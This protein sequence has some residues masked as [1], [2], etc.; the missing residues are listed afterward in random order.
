MSEDAGNTS[1]SG[2]PP[3]WGDLAEM[4]ARLDGMAAS[5]PGF[6]FQRRMDPSGALSYP[7]F[8]DNVRDVLGFEPA[9]MAVNAKG[10]LHVV[11]WADREN[12]LDAIRRSSATLSPCTE[13]FRAITRSGEVRWLKGAAKPRRAAD[14]SVL[15]DGVLIDVTDGRRAE[16]RLDMLMDHAADSIIVLNEAGNV[17]T[18]NVAA[19]RL[20]G[21]TDAELA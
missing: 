8:T 4:S 19:E 13:E 11:H 17:D 9:A 15:W 6:A 10:C 2:K 14:G 12:H 7:Y 21:W 3:A 5:L 20:F 1:G 18:V 16:L